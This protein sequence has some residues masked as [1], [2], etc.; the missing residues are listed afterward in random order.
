MATKNKPEPKKTEQQPQTEPHIEQPKPE[1]TPVR[2]MA[3]HEPTT[4]ERIE[5]LE[6]RLKEAEKAIS[7]H[8][9]YHFGGTCGL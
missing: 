4:E 6:L 2:P 5:A 8:N 7:Q 1:P 3:V 9:R